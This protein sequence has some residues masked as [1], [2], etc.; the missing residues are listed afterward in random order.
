VE[1]AANE[2]R[3]CLIDMA[4]LDRRKKL[5]ARLRARDLAALNVT[6]PLRSVSTRERIRFLREYAGD[7][8][9]SFVALIH[10]RVEHL[11]KRRRFQ[12][13]LQNHPPNAK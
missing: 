10:S 13:F 9:G 7:T 6:A 5:S 4:R 1:T 3:F 12:G 8:D 11:L 2:P